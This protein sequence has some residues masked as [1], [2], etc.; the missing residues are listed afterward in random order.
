VFL[1]YL[2]IKY[3]VYKLKSPFIKFESVCK[4]YKPIYHEFKE[5]HDID[6]HSV[7]KHTHSPF[8]L[9]FSED[10]KYSSNEEK[11][12]DDEEKQ[13]QKDGEENQSKTLSNNIN[14]TNNL[15]NTNDAK[16]PGTFKSPTSSSLVS[17]T[18]N[19]ANTTN[20]PVQNVNNKQLFGA[21]KSQILQNTNNNNN[22]TNKLAAF[23]T[24]ST[25]KVNTQPQPV[26][27]V[28]KKKPTSYC[29]CCKQRYDN[30]K[31]VL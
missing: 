29:E 30:L 11:E 17:S 28:A 21:S 10:I 23:K 2:K 12:V 13:E 24:N 20:T 18:I 4:Q 8:Q 14:N 5:W 16:L 22:N 15:N 1:F 31:Q 27:A 6:L 3:K 9:Y 7:I 25:S 19:N 26:A